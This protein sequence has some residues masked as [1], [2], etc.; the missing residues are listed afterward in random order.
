MTGPTL[1]LPP[2]LEAALIA[3]YWKAADL[4]NGE[5]ALAA[6][7]GTTPE[8]IEITLLQP[9]ML[10][11]AEAAHIKAEVEGKTMHPLAQRIALKL[12][13]RIDAQA[14]GV[15]AFEAVEL[16]KPI[17]RILENADRVRL[18][19]KEKDANAGLPVFNFVFNNGGIQATRVFEVDPTVIDIEVNT[20]LSNLDN[21]GAA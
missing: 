11:R 7:C 10:A 14:D 21:G 20:T 19:E 15:D 16:M 6:I 13:K 9:G 8:A 18:A 12:L 5:A 17:N 2:D 4:P 3:N 1:P